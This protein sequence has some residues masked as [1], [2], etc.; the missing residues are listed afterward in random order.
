MVSHINNRD[1]I[2]YL[3]TLSGYLYAITWIWHRC[4]YYFVDLVF[5][6]AKGADQ[7]FELADVIRNVI[8]KYALR[9]QAYFS[10]GVV[11]VL[12]KLA[13]YAADE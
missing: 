2:I 8:L 7:Q 11:S 1:V 9:Q 13:L 6:D 12:G 3:L 4:F 10:L 5:G